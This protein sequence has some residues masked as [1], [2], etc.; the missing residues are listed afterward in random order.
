[1][2]KAMIVTIDG[3]AGT[4]K[5]TVA[6]RVSEALKLPYYDTGAMYRSVA[7]LMK[8]ERVTLQNESG[9][10]ELLKNFHFE[11]K[12]TDSLKKYLV[13]GGDVTGEIRSSEISQLASQASTL[14]YVRQ[15]I[16]EIQL[17]LAKHGGGV[18]EGRDMGS[19]VF[20]HAE[21]KIYLTARPEMR[22]KRRAEETAVRYPDR[23]V[24]YDA[25]LNEIRERDETDSM[26][27]I[28]P[29]I[30]PQDAY[31][32]D[33]SDISIDE[34]VGRILEYKKKKRKR[35]AWTYLRG[36]KPF[37]RLIIFL[38]W[39]LAK[40][41]YRH[42]VYGLEH[43][44]PR[45]AI[46]ASNHAS[47]LDPPL[48]SISWPEEVHFVARETLFKNKLFGALIRALNTRPVRGDGGDA[49]TFRTI[50]QLI[51]QKEKVILFPEGTRTPD[52]SFQPFKMGV[53]LLISRSQGAIIPAYLAGTYHLWDRNKRFPKL[54]GRTA[55][56]FGTPIRWES[57][58]HLDKKVAQEVI[59]QKLESSILALKKWYEAGAEGIPP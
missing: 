4:G 37:Y 50:C 25:I 24:N 14:P 42:K 11:I 49:A 39:I 45:G 57:F 26:R 51:Q 5:T 44:Y 54:R 58:A 18:F 8:K 52:G 27:S 38:T 33:T 35:P 12:E 22:A 9:I 29:L 13:N 46:I 2:G 55:C 6:K 31:T 17:H 3:P 7:W 10:K 21:I 23:T 41:F 15:A 16:W 28:A 32:I 53:A 19:I 36:V 43:Y 40:I 34:V 47:F 59:T 1:M 56:V 20:P 30:C 48:L